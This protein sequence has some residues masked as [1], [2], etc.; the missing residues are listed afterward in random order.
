[1]SLHASPH[2]FHHQRSFGIGADDALQIREGF[3]CAAFN[4]QQQVSRLEA[5]PVCR[6][7]SHNSRHLWQSVLVAVGIDQSGV[8]HDGENEVGNGPRCNNG[9][10]LPNRFGRERNFLFR[11]RHVVQG[12]HIR[13]ASGILV[14]VKLDI[15]AEWK[16][17]KPPAGAPFIDKSEQLRTKAN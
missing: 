4:A 2:Q 12:V 3:D 16:S 7:A 14:A 17:G 5:S 8:D 13:H 11:H 15:T 6:T 10:P 9:H 1:M